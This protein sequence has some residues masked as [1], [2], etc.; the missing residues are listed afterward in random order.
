MRRPSIVPSSRGLSAV[1]PD[2]APVDVDQ[3]HRRGLFRE[4]DLRG[5]D[6]PRGEKQQFRVVRVVVAGALGEGWEACAAAVGEAD[7]VV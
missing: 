4:S 5:S 6:R 7:R 2:A 1:D 3:Q